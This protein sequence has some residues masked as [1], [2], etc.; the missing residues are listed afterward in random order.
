[1]KKKKVPESTV[2]LHAP[3]GLPPSFTLYSPVSPGPCPSNLPGNGGGRSRL[4]GTVLMA[5]EG[6]PDLVMDL[7]MWN[8]CYI[9]W[10]LCEN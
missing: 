3:L 1:M 6:S 8:V 4:M 2:R 7:P 5:G 10:N 9:I